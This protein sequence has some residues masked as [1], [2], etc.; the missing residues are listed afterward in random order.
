MWFL[1]SN[2]YAVLEHLFHEKKDIAEDEKSLA[3]SEAMRKKEAEEFAKYEVDTRKAIQQLG[4]ALTVL[5]K[6]A[7]LAQLS[8]QEKADL[9]ALLNSAG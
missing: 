8:K 5:K 7:S 6:F 2:V 1:G 4:G 9:Q 3:E